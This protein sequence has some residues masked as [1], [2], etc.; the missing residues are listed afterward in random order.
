MED[1]SWWQKN[2]DWIGAV[3]SMG[4]NVITQQANQSNFNQSG[5]NN[6]N[7]NLNNATGLPIAFNFPTWI[8]IVAVLGI[9]VY[10][11]KKR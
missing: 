8:P 4:G 1:Q 5:N 2:D 11:F 3:M 10:Y 9:L 7:A 6:T